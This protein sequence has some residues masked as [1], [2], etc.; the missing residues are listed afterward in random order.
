LRVNRDSVHV[1]PKKGPG[2][3]WILV[4]V[5][6]LRPRYSL[7]RREMNTANRFL[8]ST[9]WNS[10][11]SKPRERNSWR[12]SDRPHAKMTRTKD[13]DEDEMERN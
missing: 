13:D 4:V 8:P 2:L 1:A 12:D 10:S 11:E 7:G 5:L 9:S 3:C 6:V